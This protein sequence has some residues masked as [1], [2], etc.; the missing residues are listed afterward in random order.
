MKRFYEATGVPALLNT[1]FNVTGE[2]IVETPADAVACLLK[3]GIDCCV[4]EG[5]VVV[6]V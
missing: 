1:S 2:P 4:F 3:S 6:Q 5:R